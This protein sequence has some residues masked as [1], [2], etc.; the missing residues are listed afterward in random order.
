MAV[1]PDG[2]AV[3]G[4]DDFAHIPLASKFQRN[5]NRRLVIRSA[6]ENKNGQGPVTWSACLPLLLSPCSLFSSSGK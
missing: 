3:S 2:F 6:H 4:P 1:G 5:A